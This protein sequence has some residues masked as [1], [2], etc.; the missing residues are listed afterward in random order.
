MTA[1]IIDTG[2]LA[3][4]DEFEDRATQEFNSAGGANEDCHG[5]GTH[6]AGTVGSKT[7][8]VANKVKLVGVKVLSCS[9]SGTWSSVIA[10]ID[11]VTAN[12]KKPATANISLAGG[13]SD[14]VNAAVKS[15]VNSGVTSIV[16]ACNNNNMDSCLQTHANEAS[17]IVVASTTQHKAQFYFSN[18]GSCVNIFAPGSDVKSPWIG[19]NSAIRT[20]S[21]TSMASPHVCGTVA[22]YLGQDPNLSPTAVASRL[23][24]D[25]MLNARSRISNSM[26]IVGS[27]GK[28]QFT[29]TLE[30]QEQVRI[31]C[32][33]P[34]N[35]DTTEYG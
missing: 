30:V 28:K 12:A 17:A 32:R 23:L 2:I 9:G 26:F 24:A 22:L 33:D 6:V 18:R 29:S 8:G 1:Y 4:H 27:S 10:G 19:S 5:H 34:A 11:W 14:A 15:L 35:Y 3:S 31:Y 13:K 20:M 7:Y 25:S 16:A 21:A